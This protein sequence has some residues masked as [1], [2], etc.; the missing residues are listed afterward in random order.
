MP[1]APPL[2]DTPPR[3]IQDSPAFLLATL[4]SARA[5]GDTALEHVAARRLAEIG[6]RI[7]FAAIAKPKREATPR[8]SPPRRPSCS[9]SRRWPG[10]PRPRRS[11]RWNASVVY[12]SLDYDRLH[13]PQR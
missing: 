3:S 10:D 4:I 5:S 8:L 13:S 2:L 11:R 12:H 6:V 7:Q 9:P 1:G